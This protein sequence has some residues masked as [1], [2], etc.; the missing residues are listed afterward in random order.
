M[1]YLILI[2]LLLTFTQSLFAIDACSRTA[3]INYQEVLVDTSSNQKGEGL[4]FH[5][6]KDPDATKLL[7]K[8]QQGT[9][10][11]LS[12]I[13]MGTAGSGMILGGALFVP[14][15]Q[16]RA[17]IIGGIMMLGFNFL[18]NNTLNYNNE[19]NLKQAVDEY[20]RNNAP[21][22]DFDPFRNREGGPPRTSIFGLSFC[23]E[24]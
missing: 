13:I 23:K 11:H 15:Q 9:K 10:P 22:I 21:H 6:E 4:R 12:T 16:Q 24:F 3:V 17:F 1:N 19:R 5:L 7:N 14:K 2:G 8:Y 18:I 20:N